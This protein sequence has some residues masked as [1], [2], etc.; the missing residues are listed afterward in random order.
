MK[1]YPDPINLHTT[2][3]F[4]AL[5]CAFPAGINL[6]GPWRTETLRWFGGYGL[7]GQDPVDASID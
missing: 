4:A 2:R 5:A 7:E 1:H 3:S 6:Y